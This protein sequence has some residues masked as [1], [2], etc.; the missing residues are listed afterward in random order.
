[1]NPYQPWRIAFFAVTLLALLGTLAAICL[2]Y[3]YLA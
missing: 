2:A 1:M 3:A